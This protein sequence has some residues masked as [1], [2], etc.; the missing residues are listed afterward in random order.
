[1]K[2]QI[3]KAVNSN[4]YNLVKELLEKGEKADYETVLADVRERDYND[5]HRAAAPLKQAEDAVLVDTTALNFAQSYEALLAI[6][7]AK[8]A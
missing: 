2:T 8:M 1:M 6:I 7:R 4:N 5:T 3:I